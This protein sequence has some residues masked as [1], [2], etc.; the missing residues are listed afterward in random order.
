MSP[1]RGLTGKSHGWGW[2]TQTCWNG[3]IGRFEL[4]ETNP[5]DDAQVF[6]PFPTEDWM[7][8]QWR[9][10]TDAGRIEFV[11][12]AGAGVPPVASVSFRKPEDAP[13]L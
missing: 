4:R 5:L 12:S 10:L 6:A 13:Q 11:F 2:S 3:I 9:T 1:A 7:D 8:R